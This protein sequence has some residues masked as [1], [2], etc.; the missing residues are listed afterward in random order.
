LDAVHSS[1]PVRTEPGLGH[2]RHAD[3]L[4]MCGARWNTSS[5]RNEPP[6]VRS[7]IRCAGRA[8]WERVVRLSVPAYQRRYDRLART[9][10][11]AYAGRRVNHWVIMAINAFM[12]TNSLLSSPV[13]AN[14]QW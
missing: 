9:R 2:A 13:R 12:P 1:H 4:I 3:A 8:G 10:T 5:R 14:V 6:A 7:R 11:Y